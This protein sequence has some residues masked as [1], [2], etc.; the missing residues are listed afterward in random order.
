M[1]QIKSISWY[2]LR[3]RHAFES[4]V[5][6]NSFLGVIPKFKFLKSVAALLRYMRPRVH[7]DFRRGA[8]VVSRGL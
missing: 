8:G 7:R 1:D 3:M 4:Q 2:L 5:E 6:I